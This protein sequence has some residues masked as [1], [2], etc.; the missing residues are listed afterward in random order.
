MRKIL[1]FMGICGMLFHFGAAAAPFDDAAW[2]R[3]PRCTGFPIINLL[4][5]ER[6]N[7]PALTGPKNIHSLLRKEIELTEK[8]ASALLAI[9]GDDYY[10]FFINGYRVVQGPESGYPS[11]YPYY[12]LDVTEFLDGGVNCLAAPVFY[13]G[14]AIASGT[15]PTIDPDSCWP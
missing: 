2:L 5:R 14:Y 15:A 8:P 11:A 7:P 4:H 3:D 10:K 6:E 9:T 1:I 13:Q 12:Y